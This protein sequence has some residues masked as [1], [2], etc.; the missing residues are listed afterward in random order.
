MLCSSVST[1]LSCSLKSLLTRVNHFSLFQVKMFGRMQRSCRTYSSRAVSSTTLWRKTWVSWLSRRDYLLPP[2]V[3]L[4]VTFSS[5]VFLCNQSRKIWN[6]ISK[7]I[8]QLEKS[9]VF[10]KH[11]AKQV[12]NRVSKEDVCK[13][14]WEKVSLWRSA[15]A[16]LKGR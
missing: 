13:K 4:E 7:S 16:Q 14:A 5:F 15:M 6:L 2:A 10:G 1:H 12:S 3:N 8:F 9:R 11:L